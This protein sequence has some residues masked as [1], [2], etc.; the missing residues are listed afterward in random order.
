MSIRIAH[1]TATRLR[2]RLFVPPGLGPRIAARVEA[3]L[4]VHQVRYN[5]PAHP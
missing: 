4:G 2:L 5:A 3:L 1:E